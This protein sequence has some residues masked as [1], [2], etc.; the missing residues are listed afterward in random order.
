MYMWF[1]LHQTPLT[2]FGTQIP[3]PLMKTK[4]NF[5]ASDLFA[6]IILALMILFTIFSVTESS[7]N[8]DLL[9]STQP[10]HQ[11]VDTSHSSCDGTCECD[12]MECN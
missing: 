10:T 5:L 6:Y 9:G 1:P 3:L 7:I 8:L 12:G 4:T 11:C 2:Y